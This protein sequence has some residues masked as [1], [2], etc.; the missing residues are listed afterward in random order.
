MLKAVA[1]NV[2]VML[3]TT[4]KCHLKTVEILLF[5]SVTCGKGALEVFR[6]KDTSFLETIEYYSERLE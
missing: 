1:V 2:V 3:N 5:N 6:R 4:S